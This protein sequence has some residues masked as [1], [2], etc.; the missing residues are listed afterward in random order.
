M[1]ASFMTSIGMRDSTGGEH[2]RPSPAAI[3]RSRLS[4]QSDVATG[5]DIEDGG[6]MGDLP[7]VTG[8]V[9]DV[10]LMRGDRR[11]SLRSSLLSR[12]RASV[13]TMGAGLDDEIPAF[14]DQVRSIN[15][16]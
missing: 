5:I 7:S 15:H 14:D 3:R 11:A 10:E 13:S 8:R 6:D 4:L 1:D 9:S 16:L 2:D 12:S